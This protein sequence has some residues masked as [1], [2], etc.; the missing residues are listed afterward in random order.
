MPTFD[1]DIRILVVADDHLARAGLA[2]MLGDQPGCTVVG[3]VSGPE[4]A[5]AG[6]DVFSP[7]I[8]RCIGCSFRPVHSFF[9][10]SARLTWR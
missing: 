2:A 3:Q 7:D 4:H 6:V 8:V 1:G 10:H 9:G 5:D